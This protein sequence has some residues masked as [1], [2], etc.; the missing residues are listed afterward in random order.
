LKQ[1]L[2]VVIASEKVVPTFPAQPTRAV[3]RPRDRSRS[4]SN[5]TTE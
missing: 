2:T 5:A 1:L 3:D 4:Y